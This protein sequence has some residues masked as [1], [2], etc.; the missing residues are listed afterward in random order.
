MCQRNGYSYR[1]KELEKTKSESQEFILMH[2]LFRSD[3]TG[4]MINPNFLKLCYPPRW[5]YDIL[6]AMDYF[7]SA[8]V[9]YDNRMDDAIEVI[10]S[11]RNKDGQWKLP[12]NHPGQ[13]HFDMEKP[14]NPSRWNTLRA[15]RVLNHYKKDE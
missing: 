7:Q 6:K 8:Y 2:K 5:Y 12:A 1:L 4:K 14:G 3:K 11:K 13:T 10:I 9:K 15:L